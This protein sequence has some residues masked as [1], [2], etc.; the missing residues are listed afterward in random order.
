MMEDLACR[1]AV[2]SDPKLSVPGLVNGPMMAWEESTT[3]RAGLEGERI[4]T[5]CASLRGICY[6]WDRAEEP[7]CALS[8]LGKSDLAEWRMLGVAREN[9]LQV[10]FWDPFS[11]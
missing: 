3:R 9:A 7:L 4:P 5:I 10:Y 2:D 11:M 1:K 6:R 8:N